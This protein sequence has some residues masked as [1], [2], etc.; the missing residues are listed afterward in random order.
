MYLNEQVGI[1]VS[2]NTLTSS[3]INLGSTSLPL[4]IFVDYANTSPSGTFTNNINSNT[5]TM[6]NSFVPR[7]Q[8]RCTLSGTQTLLPPPTPTP[9]SI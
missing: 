2:F 3:V 7:R 8:V 1:N 4:G 9:Q 6:T 5:V